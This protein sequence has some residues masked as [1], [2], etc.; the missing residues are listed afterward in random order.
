M[1]SRGSSEEKGDRIRFMVQQALLCMFVD[2]RES[3]GA[4]GKRDIWDR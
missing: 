3:G 4:G 2:T 1:R